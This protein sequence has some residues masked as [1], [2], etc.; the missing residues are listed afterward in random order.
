M[1]DSDPAEQPGGP[2]LEAA[3]NACPVSHS[4]LRA[5]RAAEDATLADL[6][7][8]FAA[9]DHQAFADFYDQTAARVHGMALRVVLS[10]SHAEEITQEVFLQVWRSAHEFDATR[11]TAM[12]WLMTLAH[13]RAVDRVRSEQSDTNRRTAY[14]TRNADREHDQ[15]LESVSEHLEAEA[16]AACLDVLTQ[17]QHESVRL[18]YYDGLTYREIADNLG[19]AVPTI[20]TRIR[21]GLVKLKACLGVNAIA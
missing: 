11:G 13:R 6:I 5:R 17:T 10:A 1:D 16:V 15:V 2:D 4:E 12:G 14:A 8:R 7:D 9:D 21:D 18:A 20:K 19:V 3:R